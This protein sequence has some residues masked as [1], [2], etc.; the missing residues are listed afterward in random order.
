M[1]K[2]EFLREV[3]DVVIAYDNDEQG[4]SMAQRVRSQLPNSVRRTP[5]AIDWNEDLM[6]RFNWSK[7]SRS[8]QIKRQPQ[9]ERDGGLS[10]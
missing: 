5:K 1:N 2:F 10:L 9:L 8:N 6:N 3:K 4:N 7:E